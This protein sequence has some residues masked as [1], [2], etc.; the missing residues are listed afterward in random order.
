[1]V[2]RAARLSFP[3][4]ELEFHTEHSQY[5]ITNDSSNTVGIAAGHSDTVLSNAIVNFQT[6]NT[7]GDNIG[8]FSIILSGQE[9]RWNKILNV[10][11]III[12]RVD[13]NEVES[14]QPVFNSNVFTGM[15]SEVSVLGQYGDDSLMFQISGQSFAKAFTQFK[16]GLI[17]QVEQQ[18]ANMGWLWDTNA[19]LDPM[20]TESDGG[21]T[22]AGGYIP[23]GSYSKSVA[24]KAKAVANAISKKLGIKASFIFAQIGQETGMHDNNL[25]A[26]NNLSGLVYIGQKGAYRGSHQPAE[27]NGGWYAYFKNLGYYAG[28]YCATLKAKFG[29]KKPKTVEE[30][31]QILYDKHYFTANPATYAA[32][33]RRWIEVYKST[34]G[35]NSLSEDSG[36]DSD[37]GSGGKTTGEVNSTKA[38]IDKEKEYSTGV[39]FFGNTVA[40]I[41]NNL[42]N[43][44]KPYMVYSY[45]GGKK[46]LWDYLDYSGMQSW[47]DYEYLLDSSQ[48][49]NANGSLWDLLQNALRIP[50]NEMFFDSLANGKSKMVVRR[51]PFNPEDWKNLTRVR[52]DSTDIIDDEV[53]K[54]D[55][56]QYSVFVVNPAT[57]TLLGVEDG[58]LLSAY[59]QTNLSLI[60]VYGYSK[61]EVDDLY[62]SGRTNDNNKKAPNSKGSKT[63]SS[64]NS[65]GTYFTYQN[66][67]AYLHSLSHDVVRLNKDRC[68]K[69]LADQ[70]NNISAAQALDIINAYCANGYILKKEGYDSIMQTSTGGGLANTGTKSASYK[71]MADCVKKAKGDL[72]AFMSIAKSTIKNVSDEFLRQVWQERNSKGEL[73]KEGY[74]SVYDTSRKAGDA[75]GDAAATDLKFFTKLLFNWYADNFN[76][77]SGSIVVAGNPDIRVGCILDEIDFYNRNN[78]GYTG[79]RYYIESVAHRFSYTD[80]YTTTIGVTRG[81]RM[82]SS[83]E[84]DPRF[85]NLWGT[86][87]DF[88]GGY[89]GE[90]STAN[91][92]MAVDTAESSSGDD[93]GDA[94]SGAKGVAAANRAASFGY[95]FRKDGNPRINGR[96]MKEV[97]SFG[98]G[99]GASKNPLE[100]D[101]NQGTIKLDC[102]AFTYWCYKHAGVTIGGD[103]T[104]QLNDPHF[105]KVNTGLKPSNMKLGDLLFMDNCSHVMMC[106]GGG[107]FI[108]WNGSG[109]YDTSGGAQVETL[110]T[111]EGWAHVSP[112][113][114]RLK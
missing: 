65:K 29:N 31:A 28:A 81:M 62:L 10:N 109:S 112:V 27:E 5:K 84:E 69:T 20:T 113:V 70:A 33:M 108:G 39:A 42:V 72:N 30:Y 25:V 60:N 38:Q 15:I 88:M 19:E 97:Y 111:I 24:S 64:D 14:T 11:D 103:T 76:F 73:T 94:L 78:F 3:K 9:I 16:I 101:I 32:G 66:V 22:S 1:M 87:I 91:L 54:T 18:I 86:S 105:K 85:L 59:P 89:M 46:T 34:K 41:E 104:A 68:A 98:A 37:S 107:K 53:T 95:S 67:L 93:D 48:F 74:K 4:I 56:Q 79:M 21:G 6:Q 43:R 47:T 61:Y 2:K 7:L 102:S 82:P 26:H 52:I 114:A 96:K 63:S 58:I 8:S 36:G 49:S 99:H 35:K 17:S 77:Y 44:F 83:T 100:H 71:N 80:G 40:I 45:D 75:T 13:P 55:L 57:P 92:A 50:F 51:T 90:A 23:V 106:V 110:K 12:I